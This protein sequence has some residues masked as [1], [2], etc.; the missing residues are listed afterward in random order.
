[1]PIATETLKQFR[2]SVLVETGTFRGDGT[3]AALDAGFGKIYTVE[4][5]PALYHAACQRFSGDSRVELFMGSSIERLLD[6]L[7]KITEPA[8]F[9]LDAHTCGG[10]TGGAWDTPLVGEL[11]LIATHPI[12]SH[13]ILI[14]DIHLFGLDLPGWPEVNM[15]LAHI[16]PAYRISLLPSGDPALGADVL[17]AQV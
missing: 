13:T 5:Y 7:P 9:F 11:R 14:D 17:C 12:K 4:V 2:S 15:R 8:T 3:A 16:N 10:A 1:M 6:I